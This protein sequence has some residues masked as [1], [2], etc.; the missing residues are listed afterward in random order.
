MRKRPPAPEP[1]LP[2]SMY[3]P[4]AEEAMLGIFLENQA[5]IGRFHEIG[6]L[7]WFYHTTRRMLA[8]EMFWL[9]EEKETFDSVMLATHLVSKGLMDKIGGPSKIS[10]LCDLRLT[11]A[12][13]DYYAQILSEKHVLRQSWAKLEAAKADLCQHHDSLQE[14]GEVILGHLAAVEALF[15]EQ[16]KTLTLAEQVTAWQEDWEF[17]EEQMLKD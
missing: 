1:E 7:D 16:D 5:Y 12:H 17:T 2:A 9:A 10:E 8:E 11:P 14:K 3:A 15:R 6:S 4:E 13:F